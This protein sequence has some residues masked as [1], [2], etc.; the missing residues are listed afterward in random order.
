MTIFIQNIV[1]AILDDKITG[2]RHDPEGNQE[3]F[4]ARVDLHNSRPRW[5]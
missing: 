4:E 5:P 3:P 1:F 2:K